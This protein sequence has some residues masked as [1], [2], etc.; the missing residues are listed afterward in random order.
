MKE[1]LIRALSGVLYILVLV[2]A[3]YNPIILL[4]ILFVF[5]ILSLIELKKLFNID[6]RSIT[7]IYTLFV[8]LY[9]IGTYLQLKNGLEVLKP[10]SIGLALISLIINGVLIKNLYSKS[11]SLH[12]VFN[13]IVVATFYCSSAF[14]FLYLIPYCKQNYHPELLLGCFIL[15]WTNDTFAYLTGR[16]LGKHKLFERI[17]PK[18]TI[19][20]FLGGVVFSL[21]AAYVL[22]T[23]FTVLKINYW[24]VLGLIISFL[25]TYGDLVES[26][27]KREAHVKDSGTIMPGHGGLLDRLDSIIFV[28]PFVYLFLTLI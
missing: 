22:A 10:L 11:A 6:K 13:K 7:I 2:V 27:I 4:I 1:L 15:I 20:G 24:L 3:I 19:E 28:S 9:S 5:G 18:K 17:S 12:N 26:K 8:T 23:Y 25:G 21:V 16:A 14:L